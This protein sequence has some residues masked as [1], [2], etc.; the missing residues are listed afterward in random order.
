[1]IENCYL[2]GDPID[3]C[4]IIEKCRPIQ[5]PT[6][7]KGKGKGEFVVPKKI[8]DSFFLT[9]AMAQKFRIF[10]DPGINKKLGEVGDELRL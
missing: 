6:L 8:A 7:S 1:M 2:C 3:R 5:I 10:V 4:W 9:R